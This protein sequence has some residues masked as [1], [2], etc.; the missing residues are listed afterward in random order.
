MSKSTPQEWTHIKPYG[1]DSYDYWISGI[2]K[3]VSYR[4]NEFHAYFIQ[5]H[6]QNWGDHVAKPPH[7]GQHGKV[8]NSFEAAS[9]DCHEHAQT[10]KPAKKTIERAARIKEVLLDQAAQYA[11]KP[12][13]EDAA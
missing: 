1:D 12:S 10:H 11:S 7:D 6:Y 4:P 2:Y 13:Q 3:I 9:T 5:D 8:W